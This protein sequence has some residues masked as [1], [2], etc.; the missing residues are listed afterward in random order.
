MPNRPARRGAPPTR[1]KTTTRHHGPGEVPVPAETSVGADALPSGSEASAGDPVP[2]GA[3][4]EI[5]DPPTG[6]TGDAEMAV[7][8]DDAVLRT[9]PHVDP[10]ADLALVVSDAD[11]A[12]V[13][14]DPVAAAEIDRSDGATVGVLV[15]IVVILLLCVAFMLIAAGNA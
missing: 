8:A 13:P 3:P 14:F 6:E 7:A 10:D 15:G 1:A 5:H 9:A 2:A 12:T 4:A 11:Q